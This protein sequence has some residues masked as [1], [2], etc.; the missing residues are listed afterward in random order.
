MLLISVA[1]DYPRRVFRARVKSVR[2]RVNRRGIS[3]AIDDTLAETH[4]RLFRET[5]RVGDVCL[6]QP[7]REGTA[8]RETEGE[9]RDDGGR[10]S[11]QVASLAL[12]SSYSSLSC[13]YL[14]EDRQAGRQERER[15]GIEM[16][17]QRRSDGGGGG[18][19]DVEREPAG[20]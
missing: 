2:Q 20:S 16:R 10:E 11:H 1:K 18:G 13:S 19:E 3:W 15:E 7:R 12:G 5:S 8:S 9:R 4:S 17:C 14:R 6:R